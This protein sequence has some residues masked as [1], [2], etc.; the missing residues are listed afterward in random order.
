M[1][2]LLLQTAIVAND[3]YVTLNRGRRFVRALFP[4]LEFADDKFSE[5]YLS[6]YV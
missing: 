2:F 1:A 3:A 5:K 4:F 6:I